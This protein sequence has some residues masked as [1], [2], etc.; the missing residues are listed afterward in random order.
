M[1]PMNHMKKPGE[2]G[3]HLPF[4]IHALHRLHGFLL[5]FS[6]PAPAPTRVFLP[7]SFVGQSNFMNPST[8][9]ITVYT[10]AIWELPPE[11]RIVLLLG[12]RGCDH[13]REIRRIAEFRGRAAFLIEDARELQPRWF[14]QAE[15]VGIVLGST[16]LLPLFHDVLA[17]VREFGEMRA[18]GMLEGIAR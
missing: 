17:R 4:E 16:A 11:A 9:T 8:S 2:E 18:Q 14:V 13:L 15:A 7:P 12:D 10:G 1:K 5:N 3:F 6:A